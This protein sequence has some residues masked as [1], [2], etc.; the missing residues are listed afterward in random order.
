MAKMGCR[1]FNK[2]RIELEG[3]KVSELDVYP[4]AVAEYCDGLN[5]GENTGRIYRVVSDT[6]CDGKV[7][8]TF[9]EKQLTC[10][11]CDFFKKAPVIVSV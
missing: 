4:T 3:A 10:M 11:T 8:G 7:P 2:C 1:E 6:F 5:G 9:A